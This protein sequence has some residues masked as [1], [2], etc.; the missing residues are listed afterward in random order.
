L[1]G[2]ASKIHKVGK[3]ST[4]LGTESFTNI[5]I[6]TPAI[7]GRI[8][9]SPYESLQTNTSSW[10]T[11]WDLTDPSY[12]NV[13]YNPKNLT[14]GYELGSNGSQTTIYLS[15][16]ATPEHSINST[17]ILSNF[18][19]PSCCINEITGPGGDAA[20]GYWSA[21]NIAQFSFEGIEWPINFTVKWIYGDDLRT[22]YWRN[23]T[24]PSQAFQ[25]NVSHIIFGKMPSIGAANCQPI[26]DQAPAEVTVDHITGQILS[27]TILDDPTAASSALTD[28]FVTHNKSKDFVTNTSYILRCNITTR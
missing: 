24:N 6:Q 27:Y 4:E 11:T 17:S 7:R 9:C 2:V 26:I 22:D 5:T 20:I 8:E 10:L 14:T 15:D 16:Y 3:A 18:D 19:R 25:W 13:E 21:N 23:L 12:W 1:T 28:A